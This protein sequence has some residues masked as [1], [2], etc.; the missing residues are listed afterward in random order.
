VS[1]PSEPAGTGPDPQTGDPA[2]GPTP[3]VEPVPERP[4]VAGPARSRRGLAFT[5]AA[6][7]LLLDVVTKAVAVA[8][9]TPFRPVQLVDGV[10]ELDLLRNAGSAFSL[11]TGYTAVL[12]L[13]AVAV[14]VVVVRIA[15]RLRSTGWAVAF[16]LLLGGA[17]G[18]LADRVFRAPGV[19]RGH[20][21]DFIVL[22][23]W[24]VFNIA[25]TGITIAAVMI[26]VLS[27]LGRSYDGTRAR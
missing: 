4:A 14:V 17:M 19:L 12:S 6:V 21:V 22:P 10:L 15:G 23:H 8:E 1:Q 24:P 18:N 26:V 20:V 3:A 25:D 13:V 27:L 11:A 5:V 2:V 16:G 7:W 9:L